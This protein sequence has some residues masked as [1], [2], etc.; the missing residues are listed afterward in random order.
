[1]TYTDQDILELLDTDR[2]AGT[3]ALLKTYT[4]LLWSVC[5]RRLDDEEDVKEC[6]NDAFVEFIMK[7]ERFDPAVGT[8]KQYL[9]TIADRRAIDRQRKNWRRNKA[10]TAM[11]QKAVSE[12]EASAFYGLSKEDLEAALGRLKPVSEQIIRM[13]YY[14]GMTY[15]EIAAQLGLSYETVRKRGQRGLKELWRLLIIL[16]LLAALAACAVKIYR[17]FFF[18]ER[19]G[20]NWDME[21]AIYY[22]DSAP[23]AQT[24]DGIAYC[25][26]DAVWRDGRLYLRL[27]CIWDRNPGVPT[28]RQDRIVNY[29]ISHLQ[30][31][32]VPANG[33]E[34]EAMVVF[35][36]TLEGITA[37]IECSWQPAGGEA[38]ALTVT[39][40]GIPEGDTVYQINDYDNDMWYTIEGPNPV[41]TLRLTR[42]VPQE[43]LE[44]LGT[45]F[46]IED[47]AFLV[48]SG[49]SDGTVTSLSLY[50]LKETE[51]LYAFLPLLIRHYL[52]SNGRG[53]DQVTLTDSAGNLY[54]AVDIDGS[55]LISLD[56]VR[57]TFPA[58]PPGKYRLNIPYICL[59]GDQSTETVDLP[60]PEVDREQLALDMDILFPDGSG[61]RLT[62]VTRTW[63]ENGAWVEVGQ[64][65]RIMATEEQWQYELEWE[66]ISLKNLDLRTA[67]C[68]IEAPVNGGA[69]VAG[70]NILLN[71]PGEEAPDSLQLRF[72][73]P[74]YVLEQTISLAVTVS[75]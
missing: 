41:Y 62:G 32:G 48:K 18:V 29:Y 59:T 39:L 75:G 3:T 16:L 35:T 15:R 40:A 50:E 4:G 10:E 54:P 55:S 5:A 28:E 67:Q 58:V 30:L 46:R 45:V 42:A 47:F 11:Q 25:L 24:A 17:Q 37:E 52:W 34:H 27:E 71:I 22:L 12:Q 43:N 13:K 51:S 14:K 38:A 31:D 63:V 8:L 44:E 26:T 19:A 7:R 64:G 6:V 53:S 69:T 72:S 60:L 65:E 73:S 70:Q 33:V 74:V 9:C 20:F 56:E 49:H 1:M 57:M 21:Q 61:L 36:S 23:P 66:P 68:T 2:D